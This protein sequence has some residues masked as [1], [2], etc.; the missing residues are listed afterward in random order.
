VKRKNGNSVCF[1]PSF[2]CQSVLEIMGACCDGL[3][4]R[5]APTKTADIWHAIFLPFDIHK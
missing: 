5:N 1:L 4:F 2:L 3:I